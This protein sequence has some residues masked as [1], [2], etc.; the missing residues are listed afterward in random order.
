MSEKATISRPIPVKYA[1][2]EVV[3]LP[4]GSVGIFLLIRLH[5]LL[6]LIGEGTVVVHQPQF[7][8]LW[9]K[10]VCQGKDMLSFGCI[11]I[12]NQSIIPVL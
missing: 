9:W 10:V 4:I 3:L 1:P 8:F 5:L 2:V 6:G 7:N 12:P 11:S